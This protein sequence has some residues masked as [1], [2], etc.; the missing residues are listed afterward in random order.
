[1]V[2]GFDSHGGERALAYIARRPRRSNHALVFLFLE[3]ALDSNDEVAAKDALGCYRVGLKGSIESWPI[4]ATL[5]HENSLW[6]MP[7]FVREVPALGRNVY[8]LDSFGDD[9]LSLVRSERIEPDLIAGRP[10]NGAF[11]GGALP[12]LLDRVLRENNGLKLGDMAWW[13]ALAAGDAAESP[14]GD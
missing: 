4:V 10:S 7:K 1:M 8:F 2:L 6:P 13:R 5:P 3:S 9:L 14:A 12:Y 11:Q